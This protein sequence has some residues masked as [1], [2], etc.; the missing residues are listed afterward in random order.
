MSR[1]R[2]LVRTAAKGLLYHQ[3]R[4]GLALC[5]GVERDH[6]RDGAEDR[7]WDGEEE[8]AVAWLAGLE[9]AHCRVE[10]LVRLCSVV[11]A[12]VEADAA[13]EVRLAQMRVLLDVDALLVDEGGQID[14]AAAVAE[15]VDVT[16]DVAEQA[17]LVERREEF[18]LGEIARRA[19]D[20]HR[21]RHRV[22]GG[23]IGER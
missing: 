7:R 11:A 19:E 14:G 17:E 13:A 3:P 21:Q 10:A 23:V 4:E 18:L 20:N 1:V 15:D 22:Q 12:R 5:A 6:L 9:G 2:A 8:E 16:R